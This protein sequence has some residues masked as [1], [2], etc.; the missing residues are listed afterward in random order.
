MPQPTRAQ[1]HLDKPLTNISISYAQNP[2][3]FI[4]DK[5]FPRVSVAKQSDKYF[6]YDKGYLYRNGARKRASGTESAGT[7]WK[8]SE[9]NYNADVWAL[10]HDIADQDRSNADQPINLDMDTTEFLTQQMLIS[11]EVEW[12]SAFFT[13]SLWTGS[14]TAGDITPGDLWDTVAGTPIEDIRA[15][16][17]SVLQKTG[18]RPNMLVLGINV[19][20][21]LIDNADILDRIKYTQE[22]SVSTALLARLF[23]VDNVVIAQAV[24]N[25]EEEEEDDSISFI[26]GGNDALLCF[27]QPSPGIKKPSAGYTFVWSGLAGNDMGQGVSKFHMDSTKSDRVEI[28]SAYDQ[29]QVDANLGAFFDEVVS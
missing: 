26:I 29:K 20:D 9:D 15:Q 8:M 21:A 3:S 25:T 5:V 11:R 13:T 18:Y 17:T 24:Q 7:G 4:A 6:T 2:D 28:E 16:S 27:S 1:I 12:A 22:G 19:F 10:H 23:D 14:S